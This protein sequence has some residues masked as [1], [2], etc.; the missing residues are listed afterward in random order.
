LNTPR[1]N[2]PFVFVSY[3]HEN[4]REVHQEINRIKRQG[5]EIW[6]DMGKLIAG[7]LW[8]ISIR[9]AIETCACFMVFLTRAAVESEHVKEEIAQALDT[10]KPFICVYWEKVEF[11]SP[12]QGKIDKIQALK[13]YD[14]HNPEYEEGLSKGL[15]EYIHPKEIKP[16]PPGPPPPPP[17][18]TISP[19]AIYFSLALS[20]IFFVLVAMV[21]M[22]TPFFA[23]QDPNDPLNN[24]LAGFLAGGLFI[25]IAGGLAV[26]AFIVHRKYGREEE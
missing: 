14:M 1:P 25:V 6:Y 13:R 22:A 18:P 16:I 9:E 17:P 20:A 12:L 15:S 26:A 19:K 10:Q 23:T 3:S 4:I 5:Y 24:R 2:E 8:D 21:A 7:K 11:L